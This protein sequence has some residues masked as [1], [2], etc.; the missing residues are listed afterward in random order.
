[1]SEQTITERT[2][3]ECEAVAKVRKGGPIMIGGGPPFGNW[4]QMTIYPRG[5]D[6]IRTLDFC[7]VACALAWCAREVA[8]E[9]A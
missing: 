8:K 1:M 9:G 5:L 6:S 2:C 4:V 3:D 7:G